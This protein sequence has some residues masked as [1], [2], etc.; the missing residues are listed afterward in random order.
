MSNIKINKMVICQDCGC[1]NIV[2]KEVIRI[3]LQDGTKIRLCK[4]CAKI[5]SQDLCDALMNEGLWNE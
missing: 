1:T 3:K 5:L 4:E 2:A